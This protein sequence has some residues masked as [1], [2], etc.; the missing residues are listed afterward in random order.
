MA[1]PLNR[2]P[3]SAFD[4]ASVNYEKVF[5]TY[6]GVEAA[7]KIGGLV[8]YFKPTIQTYD[9]YLGRVDHDFGTQ[10]PPLRPLL[11]R[12]TLIQAPIYDPTNLA[13]YTLLL[14]HPLSERAA[15]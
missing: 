7:G 11:L 10:R 15:L 12:T 2:I 4:P 9:E 1:Y 8:N 14:Q 5:P 3:T 13:S 6:S